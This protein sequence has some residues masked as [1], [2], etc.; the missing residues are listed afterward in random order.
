M[1]ATLDNRTVSLWPVA[2]SLQ[3]SGA[4]RARD[5]QIAEPTSRTDDPTTAALAA[6]T[7][8]YQHGREGIIS[9]DASPPPGR[10]GDT[11]Q[12]DCALDAHHPTVPLTLVSDLKRAESPQ[13][14][15]TDERRDMATFWSRLRTRAHAPRGQHSPKR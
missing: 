9:G 4:G 10:H 3:R 5:P 15:P 1:R 12:P 14:P 7:S 2:T 8:S 13:D 11:A 6:I